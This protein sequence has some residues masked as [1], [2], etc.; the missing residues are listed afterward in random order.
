MGVWHGGNIWAAIN[1]KAHARVSRMTTLLNMWT[2]NKS[3]KTV[4]ATPTELSWPCMFGHCSTHC[5]TCL[6]WLF[7]A[8]LCIEPLAFSCR[9]LRRLVTFSPCSK[10]GS[11]FQAGLCLACCMLRLF[12]LLGLER[13]LGSGGKALSRR[14]VFQVGNPLLHALCLSLP[15]S[16]SCIRGAARNR[17]EPGFAPRT[18]QSFLCK[19]WHRT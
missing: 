19:R 18:A 8:C 9:V 17:H 7:G 14:Q 6:L 3:C 1:I 13:A 5:S 10:G 15:G 4:S 2:C 16:A 11:T 12:G